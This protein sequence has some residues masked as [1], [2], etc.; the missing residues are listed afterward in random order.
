MSKEAGKAAKLEKKI[1]ILTGIDPTCPH[2]LI[3]NSILIPSFDL[4]CRWTTS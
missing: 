3:A 1:A 4:V 2:N